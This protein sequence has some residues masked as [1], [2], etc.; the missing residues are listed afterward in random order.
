MLR[1]RLVGELGL[2]AGGRRLEPPA[3]AKARALLAWLALHP[4]THSRSEVAGTFWPDVLEES[5]RASLRTALSAV[6]RALAEA[7]GEHLVATR[8]AVGLRDA[9]VDVLAFEGLVA[10]G[11]PEEALALADGELLAGFDEEWARDARDR[12]RR[13]RAEVLGELADRAGPAEAVALARARLALDPLSEDAARDLIGRLADAGDRAGALVAYDEL[14]ERL[15]TTLAIAPSAETRALADRLRRG[16]ARRPASSP[17]LDRSTAGVFVGRE[18]ERARA[19]GAR[20]LVVIEGDAG[21]GKTRLALELARA[22]RDEGGVALVGRCSEEPLRPYEAWAEALRPL[23]DDVGPVD[24]EALGRLYGERGDADADAEGERYR[25]FEAV[26]TLLAGVAGA[27][28]VLVVLD[29]LHWADRPTLLLLA[30]LVRAPE[31]APARLVG[32]YRTG[33]LPRDHPLRALLADARRE[34]LADRLS[35]RGLGTEATAALVTASTG[36]DTPAGVAQAV[37]AETGGN[38]FF[39]VEVARHLAETGAASVGEV[40]LPESVREVVGRRLARLGEPAHAVLR[41][42]AVLGERFALDGLEGDTDALVD[43]LDAALD[44]GLVGEEPEAPGRYAFAHALVRQTLYEELSAARRV[45]AHAAA[46]RRLAALREAGR[47]VAAA[48]LAHH[49]LEAVPVVDPRDAAREAERAAIEAT[50]ALAW[51]D[52]AAHAA[53]GLEALEWLEAQ[54]PEL[55]AR[56]LLAQGEAQMRAG[57][58]ATARAAL[59]EAGAAFAAQ[60]RQEDVARAALALGGVGIFIGEPDAEVAGALSGALQAMPRSAH[61]TRVRLL[62]R[63]AIERYY[64]APG[65]A[66]RSLSEE[67]LAEAGRA[68]DDATLAAAL[69]ARHVAL[70]DAAHVHERLALADE[71]IAVAERADDRET[72]LQGRNW[73]VVDLFELGRIDAWREQVD[74]HGAMAEALRL[75]SYAWYTPLWH[76]VHALLQGR[77]ADAAAHRERAR[78]LGTA[79]GDAN[80]ELFADMLEHGDRLLHGAWNETD[81]TFVEEHIRASPAGIAYRSAYTWMLAGVGRTAEARV[82]LAAL[83]PDRFAAIPFDANWLSAM[84]ELAEATLLLGDLERAAVVHDLL[85]PYGDSTAASGRSVGQYGL[86]G[87][88]RGRLGLALDAPDAV[89]QLERALAFYDRHGW[90]PYAVRTRAALA[91]V[92]RGANRATKALD[93]GSMGHDRGMG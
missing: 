68:G 85:A 88:L 15:R 25:V 18:S 16:T 35:L 55:R 73:R 23:V 90:E 26:R 39:V 43:A 80:T 62:A 45:R 64:E 91:G 7:A 89:P 74:D 56:L 54:P 47:P 41:D 48:E 3:P 65:D 27:W 75:P 20:G 52:A 2:E 67:A 69:N 6:R 14:R 49:L 32:T 72:A 51:E 33:D 63:L 22:L 46:A 13:R 34:R 59:R 9:W 37:H 10:A 76:A 21:V 50:A 83:E 84:A 60:G 61:R 82:E 8:E 78:A 87:E 70:W 19:T 36:A 12:Q 92:D 79:A 71:M 38:P 24:R 31:G 40:G 53:R 86:V 81:F 66:R 28:P 93:R 44:A 11:R 4:G 17:L 1:V 5:A 57:D 29:D 30:H 58:R 42:A 77:Y